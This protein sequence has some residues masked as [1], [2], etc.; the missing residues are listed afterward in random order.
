MFR[1]RKSR[2][3]EAELR[4]GVLEVEHGLR[5]GARRD[6]TRG[7]EVGGWRRRTAVVADV[8]HDWQRAVAATKQENQQHEAKAMP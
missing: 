7:A 6:V 5:G 4:V 2:A 8:E 3:R 1:G